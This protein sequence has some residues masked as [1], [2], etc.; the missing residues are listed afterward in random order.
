MEALR[1]WPNGWGVPWDA[2]PL[3]AKGLPYALGIAFFYFVI[4]TSLSAFSHWISGHTR[5]LRKQ[6]HAITQRERRITQLAE[7]AVQ[8]RKLQRQLHEE[9][10]RWE[11]Q[12]AL[13]AQELRK[14]KQEIQAAD[15]ALLEQQKASE[16]EYRST[17]RWVG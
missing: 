6:Y 4:A 11:C 7:Q 12:A 15:R 14:A 9:R 8:L 1:W 10:A 5:E 16:G 3:N 17:P 2:D 13:Q